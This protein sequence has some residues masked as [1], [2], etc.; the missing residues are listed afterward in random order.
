MHIMDISLENT[1]SNGDAESVFLEEYSEAF[2]LKSG[3]FVIWQ[4]FIVR[5]S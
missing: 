4:V 5:L 1:Q 3:G 2:F